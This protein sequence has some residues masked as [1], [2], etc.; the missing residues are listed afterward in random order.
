[1]R[2]SAPS[3]EPLPIDQMTTLEFMRRCRKLRQA[4]VA[5]RAKLPQTKISAF[6][7]GELAPTPMELAA[8]AAAL[9]VDPTY[10]DDLMVAFPKSAKRRREREQGQGEA[11]V[12]Q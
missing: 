8:L 3:P 9:D 4:D 1:M 10:A 6:E 7:R 11:K 5:Y 2:R 12:T